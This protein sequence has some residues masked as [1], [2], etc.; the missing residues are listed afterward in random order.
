MAAYLIAKMHITDG[1]DYG[2]Y[3]VLTPDIVRRF[4]GRFLTR[5]GEKYSLEGREET[6]RVVIVEFPSMTDAKHFYESIEYTHAR[7]LRRHAA[8][9]VQLFLVEGFEAQAL[10]SPS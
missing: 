9:S 3:K 5:G 4:N 10:Q 7:S 6:R 1:T 2:A 8:T